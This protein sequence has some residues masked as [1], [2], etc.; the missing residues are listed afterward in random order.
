MNLLHY[1]QRKFYNLTHPMLGKILML[2]RVVEERSVG[3][4]RE[5]EVTPEFLKATVEEYI[6]HGYRFVSIDQ[7]C[8]ILHGN[9]KGKPFIC[10][11]FDDGYQDTYE[12]A[13]PL[14]KS[15]NIPFVVYITTGFVD[16]TAK[17]W[18]YDTIDVMSWEQIRSMDSDPLCTIGAHTLSHHRITELSKEEAYREIYESKRRLEEMLGHDICHFSYPH[19]DYNADTLDIVKQIGFVSCLKAWGGTIRR[20]D[21]SLFELHRI[22]LVQE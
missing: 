18:W 22:E 9:D 20:G 6:R 4:N 14:L 16:N 3:E 12:V 8:D 7:V 19:G 2:H 1:I 15:L 13:Y 11:T 17:M 21:S 10:L 5:L